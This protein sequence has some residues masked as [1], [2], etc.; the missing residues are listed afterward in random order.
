MMK[1]L[2]SSG[3]LLALAGLGACATTS[4]ALKEPEL[5]PLQNPRSVIGIMPITTPQPQVE[6]HVS[7]ANSLWRAGARSFFKDQRASQVGDILTVTIDITDTASL[8]NSTTTNRV[9]EQ[10]KTVSGLFG[11]QTPLERA[12]PGPNSLSTGLN[13]SSTSSA[14][15]TGT[16]N[17][18]EKIQL[19][20]AAVI[21]DVLPNGNFIVAG[22][23]EVKVNSEVRELLVS[24][25]IRPQDI[26][27]GN[28]ILHT[29]MAEARISYGGRGDL[30]VVQRAAYGQRAL[31]KVLPF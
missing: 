12:L 22:R 15:G 29:Q 11:L 18:S 26:S 16:V 7:T 4:N 8:S 3:A 14:T 9:G 1:L 21:T 19:S 17:R 20:V 6:P 30:S 28:T 27:A 25:I 2:K 13:T 5:S 23:Q 10:D 24:G 31:D